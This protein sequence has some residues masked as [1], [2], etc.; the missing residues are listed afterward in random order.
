MV[1][2]NTKNNREN[3]RVLILDAKRDK[4]YELANITRKQLFSLGGRYCYAKEAMTGFLTY[5]YSCAYVEPLQYPFD[6]FWIFDIK[7][8]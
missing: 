3:Y 7:I 5:S 1:D 2:V 4:I 6:S 8:T